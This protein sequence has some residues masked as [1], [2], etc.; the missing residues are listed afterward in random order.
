MMPF[1]NKVYPNCLWLIFFGWRTQ[2]TSYRKLCLQYEIYF[3]ASVYSESIVW[4]EN[5]TILKD[6]QI[7]TFSKGGFRNSR[8]FQNECIEK[9]WED[10]V[11]TYTWCN[12]KKY[13][14]QC[15]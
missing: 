4:E 1:Y 5:W 2:K 14:R 6:Y 13:A 9:I 7:Y 11:N 12:S 8:T 15:G 3:K 10:L